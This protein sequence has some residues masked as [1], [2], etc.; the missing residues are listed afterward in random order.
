MRPR[1]PIIW[2]VGSRLGTEIFPLGEATQF[3][4]RLRAPDGT[5]I[6]RS[7][8]IAL[9][10]LDM[11]RQAVGPENVDLTIGYVGT[12]PSSYP[13]N[14]VFQWT[15]GPEE[16]ILWV[17]LKRQGGINVER[18]KDELRAKLARELP[19]VRCSFE[20]ADIVN[21]VMSFGSPTPV[22]VAVSGPNFAETRA[23][24]GQAARRAGQ[25]RRPPRSSGSP[26]AR[27]SHRRRPHRS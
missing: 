16:A 3:R 10:V 7:E 23:Y 25:D 18:L 26:V 2:A 22:E 27:I 11:I 20:P 19:G 15:R 17:A 1:P 12:I 9:S 6:G 24:A 8:Q 21:E 14:A 5:H 4:L 13:I